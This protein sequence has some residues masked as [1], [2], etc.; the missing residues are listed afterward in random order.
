MVT[1]LP[2]G[3]SATAAVR[4]YW[5]GRVRL[6]RATIWKALVSVLVSLVDWKGLPL[7][8]KG[9]WFAWRSI[10]LPSR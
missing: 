6:D 4:Q 1:T 8:V 9:H 2:L 10:T 5:L 7:D 3:G